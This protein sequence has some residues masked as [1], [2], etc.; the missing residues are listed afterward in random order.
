MKQGENYAVISD[1]QKYSVHDGPGIRTVIFFKGCPL[2]CIW[3]ANPETNMRSENVMYTVSQCIGCGKCL[4]ACPQTAVKK[5]DGGIWID[6]EKC[7]CCGVCAEGCYSGALKLIGKKVTL[8][9][10]LRP[11]SDDAVFYRNSGG[12]ITLSGGECT[13]QSDFCSALLKKVKE[14][15]F[16]TAV[17]TCGYCSEKSMEQILEHTDFILFDIK[18]F[19]ENMHRKYTG[20]GLEQILRNLAC[21]AWSGRDLILRYPYIPGV[22][23]S[24][25]MYDW[26]SHLARK[27]KAREIH[28]LP[29][30]QLGQSK[31]DGIRQE[32][33][34]GDWREPEQEEMFRA[35]ERMSS[36]GVPVNIGGHGD[37][38][39]L[40]RK[41]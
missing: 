30:H 15:G 24:E 6:D 27:Y 18:H 8:E 1:I 12:G 31:W 41:R 32:Y 39:W 2:R 35:A 4:S 14:M 38:R 13:M 20:A 29:F 36:A 17:E 19:D 25:E 7:I 40:D 26:V 33:R 10:V 11:F 23:A 37:Y 3:C 21:A 28:I 22:N 34:C 5:T 9:E 16:N